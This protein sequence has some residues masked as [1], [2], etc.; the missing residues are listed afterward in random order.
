MDLISDLTQTQHEFKTSDQKL[1]L[2]L[3]SW[4]LSKDREFKNSSYDKT[5][6]LFY[7]H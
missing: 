5:E 7:I 3:A 2:T 6:L 1:P 4:L